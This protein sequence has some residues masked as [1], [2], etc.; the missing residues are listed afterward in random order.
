MGLFA[1]Q[2]IVEKVGHMLF[3]CTG[4]GTHN[5]QIA[6]KV[7][8]Y[9]VKRCVLDHIRP[10]FT[11]QNFQCSIET[12]F[13]FETAALLCTRPAQEYTAPTTHLA[14]IPRHRHCSDVAYAGVFPAQGGDT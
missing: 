14:A 3:F 8:Q 4:A 10:P 9:R 5:F 2:T 11:L 13:A 6:S 1:T 12:I 7:L